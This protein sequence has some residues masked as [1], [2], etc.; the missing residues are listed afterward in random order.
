MSG[1][2]AWRGPSRLDG[3]Q[4]VCIVT[5]IGDRKQDRTSNEKIGR[6]MVQTWILR[7][8]VSPIDAVHNGS[9]FSICGDCAL[10]GIIAKAPWGYVNKLRGCYVNYQNAPRAIW[11][12]YQK[13]VYPPLE[14]QTWPRRPTRLGAYGD[15]SAVPYRVNSNIVRRGDKYVGYTHQWRQRK[16]QPMRK[17]CMASV[18]SLE[19]KIEANRMGWRTF[20]ILHD[21]DQ[22]EPDEFL[23]PASEEA[24]YRLTCDTCTACSGVGEQLT[25]I[26]AANVAIWAHG[27]KAVLSGLNQMIGKE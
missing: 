23:C 4:I 1:A 22:L 24:G 5:G 10:R 18:N 27:S 11:M 3:E 20:R 2:V 8:D 16:F 25:R 19:E 7:E 17:F 26:K 14:E 15:P 9:D 6:D 13:G 21:G 12:A